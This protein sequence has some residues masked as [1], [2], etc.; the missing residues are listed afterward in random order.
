MPG[1]P[2]EREKAKKP[3]NN[4]KW[5]QASGFKPS[6]KRF[7]AKNPQISEAMTVF[8]GCKR[9]IPPEP[10]PGKMDDHKLGGALSGYMDCHLDHDVVLVYKA[11][12]N[13]IIKLL[14][15][16]DHAQLKGPPA[17]VLAKL[18]KSE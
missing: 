16:C 7:K 9:A 8:D 3:R 14:R 2:E 13:G 1:R 18:L 11:L 17:K 5:P 12:P 15:V 4:A 6:W 10:L